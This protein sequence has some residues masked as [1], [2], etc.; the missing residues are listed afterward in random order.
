[1]YLVVYVISVSTIAIAKYLANSCIQHVIVTMVELM[2]LAD[3]H[4]ISILVRILWLL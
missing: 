3:L 2:E 4:H 1:M